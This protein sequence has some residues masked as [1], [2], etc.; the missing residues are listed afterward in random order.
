M[1]DNYEQ[2][3]GLNNQSDMPLEVHS[4]E[5]DDTG[6]H[7]PAN[8]EGRALWEVPPGGI[9]TSGNGYLRRSRPDTY[10][11]KWSKVPV[12]PVAAQELSKGLDERDFRI[13]V[14]T[15][16]MRVVTTEQ[17]ARAFFDSPVT[18]RKRVR[19]LRERRF[20]ASPEVDHQVLGAAV[21]H[22]AGIH[23]APL[24]LDWNGKYLLEHQH[25]DLRTWNPATTA[26][27]N[28]Q[29]GHTLG[30]SELW[31]YMV[32]AARASNEHP[33]ESKVE[34]GMRAESGS[35]MSHDKS[36]DSPQVRTAES[37]AEEQAQKKVEFAVG[38]LNERESVIYYECCTGWSLELARA[39]AGPADMEVGVQSDRAVRKGKLRRE[40][41]RPL[42]RPDATLVL[43][44]MPAEIKRRTQAASNNNGTRQS[45]CYRGNWYD[46]L[47][48]TV[49]SPRALQLAEHLG[50]TVYKLLFIEMETGSNS[51]KDVI[52]KVGRYNQLYRRLLPGGD[53]LPGYSWTALFGNILPRILVVVRDTSQVEAQVMLW[54][55]HYDVKSAGSVIL[56]N[57]EVL[58]WVYAYDRSSLLRYPCWLDVMKPKAP[59]WKTLGSILG[60]PL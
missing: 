1:A 39:T 46:S 57:L 54:R 38:L 47:L 6:L 15:E 55:T 8:N 43:A 17:I 27:V 31:S 33:L 12:G 25:H 11:H 28:S 58:S 53:T 45:A 29:F 60:L 10:H 51:S 40:S 52:Q 9:I 36:S 16:Q 18:A 5:P 59:E 30:V 14:M 20:L 41:Y 3:T 2:G 56:A 13:L 26:Q 37:V 44:A 24:V 48:P 19:S 22:R 32:A 21:G 23:N 34:R 35:E 42:V 49:P 50:D 4:H 7:T